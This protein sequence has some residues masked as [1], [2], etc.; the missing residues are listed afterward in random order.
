MKLKRFNTKSPL[1]HRF[2]AKQEF[3]QYNKIIPHDLYQDYFEYLV[4]F[5]RSPIF[6]DYFI[7][8][9]KE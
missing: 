3:L 7:P 8:P 1:G 5:M 2:Y 9:N 4:L 6:M